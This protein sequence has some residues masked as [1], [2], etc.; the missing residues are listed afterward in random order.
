MALSIRSRAPVLIST[1]IFRIGN[2]SEHTAADAMSSRACGA[3]R[4][5]ESNAPS[6]LKI[7]DTIQVVFGDA[8]G[9]AVG[10]LKLNQRG[11]RWRVCAILLSDQAD[12]GGKDAVVFATHR[13]RDRG[14]FHVGWRR[15]ISWDRK[16]DEF[17][18]NGRRQRK[19]APGRISKEHVIV[20]GRRGVCLGSP[21]EKLGNDHYRAAPRTWPGRHPRSLTNQRAI[22]VSSQ[23]PHAKAMSSPFIVVV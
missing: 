21:C 7:S 13:N 5:L 19:R 2:G 1:G 3:A 11:G 8:D 16:R 22:C 20:A 6:S 4:C 17:L 9:R 23:N 10:K 15:R 18:V 14:R 12:G